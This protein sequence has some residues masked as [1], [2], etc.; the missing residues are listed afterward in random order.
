MIDQTI[1]AAPSIV[2]AVRVLAALIFA[3]ALWGKAEHWT[4]FTGVIG[5]YKVL[6]Q[7][8]SVPAAAT[9]LVLEAMVVGGIAL[10]SVAPF[11]MALAVF[12][13]LGF[14]VA[15]AINLARG[16]RDIDCGCFQS[17]LRQ[18]LDWGLVV[19]NVILAA[20][21]APGAAHVGF[22]DQPLGWIDGVGLGLVL[23]LMHCIASALIALREPAAAFQRRFA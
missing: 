2:L 3:T 6:P 12:L 23:F 15:M 13:L 16:N 18:R 20:L 21:V 7:A 4:A 5:Q 19:R 1:S 10:P 22:P 14:A 17:A 8:L 11:A 9:I